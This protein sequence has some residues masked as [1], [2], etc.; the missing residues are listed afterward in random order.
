MNST[1]RYL[2]SFPQLLPAG[3]L[4]EGW[5]TFLLDPV[6]IRGCK[7]KK[8]SGFSIIMK[9][10]YQSGLTSVLLCT[11]NRSY[12][13]QLLRFSTMEST[14]FLSKSIAN[15]LNF[16]DQFC[17]SHSILPLQQESSQN[18]YVNEQTQLCPIKTVLIKIAGR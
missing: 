2:M 12:L 4:N 7:P 3:N 16:A 8:V 14:K 6:M 13:C 9:P 1:E 15:I 17:C 5:A 11:Q 10:T 18:Q